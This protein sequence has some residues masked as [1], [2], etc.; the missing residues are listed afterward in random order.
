VAFIFN[1]KDIAKEVDSKTLLKNQAESIGDNTKTNT[2]MVV[3]FDQLGQS[4]N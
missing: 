3:S 1:T 4:L 2:T